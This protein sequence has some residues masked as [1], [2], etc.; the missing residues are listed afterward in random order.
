[1]YVDLDIYISGLADL[2]WNRLQ[3]YCPPGWKTE[4]TVTEH[5]KNKIKIYNVFK[6][7]KY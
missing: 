1:M 4:W 2:T 6:M 5:A 3:R 7:I